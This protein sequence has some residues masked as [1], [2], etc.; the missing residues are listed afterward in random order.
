MK[1]FKNILDFQREFSTEEKCREYLEQQRWDGTPACPFCGSLNVCRF[2]NGKVF[3]CR[4]RQCRKKFSVLVGSVYENTK[5][6]LTKWFLATYILSVHSKGISSLQL[7]NW[8]GV[9]QAT[10]W[11]LNHRIRKMLTVTSPE[12][13]ENIVEVDETYVGGSE[14]NKH[15]S[16]RKVKGGAGGKTM[17]LGAVERG[18]KVKTRVIAKTDEQNVIP[19]LKEFVAPD[20]TMVT[21]EHHCYSK[22]HLDY[23]HKTVNHRGKEYVRREDI[24]VHTNSIEGF[25]N[26]LKKQIDG[27][28][29]SVSPK[30]LQ[31]YCDENAFRYNSRALFQD[32]RF[33]NALANC[34]GKLPYKVLTAN[35]ET[36]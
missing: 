12:Q 35:E 3:K 9:R 32:E 1:T 28:H 21:D 2:A 10:A 7:S 33:A 27:I 31:R 11:H 13:L 23:T 16:K 18:G 22:V 5:I 15:A 25:W 4:E 34:Q 30:H 24:L 17:V 8:L 6:P 26:I 19:V 36:I 29:H 20:S 14:S